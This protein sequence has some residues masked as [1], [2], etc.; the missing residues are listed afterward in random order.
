MADYVGHQYGVQPAA[1]GDLAAFNLYGLGASFDPDKSKVERVTIAGVE[2]PLTIPDKN[3][4][5]WT[6]VMQEGKPMY[7]ASKPNKRTG[8]FALKRPEELNVTGGFIADKVKRTNLLAS[9]T[10]ALALVAM[11]IAGYFIWEWYSKKKSSGV[12]F[13]FFKRKPATPAPVKSETKTPET[14]Q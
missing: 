5:G 1:L 12:K 7:R 11:G 8:K 3:V 4:G 13:T 14:K 6:L 10:S 2:Y 9:G